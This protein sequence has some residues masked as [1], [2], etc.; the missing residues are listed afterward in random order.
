MPANSEE[1]LWADWAEQHVTASE[2]DSTANVAVT[3]DGDMAVHGKAIVRVVL[4]CLI[5]A[6]TSPRS[7]VV[8]CYVLVLKSLL[9]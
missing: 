1:M 9:P 6:G 2:A 8:L 5:A 3:L 4:F 7:F